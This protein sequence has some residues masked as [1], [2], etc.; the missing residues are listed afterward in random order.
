MQLL[1]LPPAPE[2]EVPPHAPLTKSRLT[3]PAPQANPPGQTNIAIA[4]LEPSQPYILKLPQADSL[5]VEAL[6]VAEGLAALAKAAEARLAQ[7][8]PIAASEPDPP[9]ANDNMLPLAMPS[10]APASP[11]NRDASAA[12]EPAVFPAKP[13][14]IDRRKAS[15]TRTK[16][17]RAGSVAFFHQ[18]PISAGARISKSQPISMPWADPRVTRPSRETPDLA[19]HRERRSLAQTRLFPLEPFRRSLATP[20]ASADPG[21]KSG[22]HKGVRWEFLH[23]LQED[24]RS[25]R[26]P[27]SPGRAA[28]GSPKPN[29]QRDSVAP[30]LVPT[31]PIQPGFQG[32]LRP[33]DWAQLIA[34]LADFELDGPA[35]NTGRHS[36]TTSRMAAVARR[37]QERLRSIPIIGPVLH[38]WQTQSW[39][40]RGLALAIPVLGFIAVKPSIDGSLR[41]PV[42]LAKELPRPVSTVIR[43]EPTRELNANR[44][45]A[46]GAAAVPSPIQQ[47]AATPEASGTTTPLEI[48]APAA[49]PAP[50]PAPASP[51]TSH[52]TLVAERGPKAAKPA[53][54]IPIANVEP[55]LDKFDRMLL[56]RAAVELADDFSFGLDS[57][58]AKSS[59]VQWTYD[60]TGFVR[61]NGLAIYRPSLNL[62]D[63]TVEF[64]AKIDASAISWVVRAQDL[65]NYMVVKMVQR[66]GGP[67]PRYTIMR[68][69]VING[70]EGSRIEHPLPLNLYKDTLF[71][72][73]MDIRGSNYAVL[74]QDSVVDSWTDERFPIGGVGFFT[75]IGEEA[76]IRWVQ[77]TYQND[78]IGKLC[79]WLA[80]KAQ[81]Q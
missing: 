80:P 45:V 32:D 62:T 4:P 43:R 69:P 22:Q 41:E 37:K 9:P 35:N 40:V 79:A 47:P 18:R 52:P 64:L 53:A 36:A 23:E 56:S 54:P 24:G 17:K 44:P 29:I 8:N 51:G 48:P 68:Y 81:P 12:L 13:E 21:S 66:G 2:T 1:Q 14:V 73:R 61:P 19:S 49:K 39:A 5:R 59:A 78:F 77:V 26:R 57:W 11:S 70:R 33:F 27:D 74:V 3:L 6:G 76:R 30:W 50:K 38:F 60:P 42:V 7:K 55:K 67:L 31:R 28:A 15:T 20:K 65:N 46:T 16:L 34:R 58:D 71:R 75:G 63:Y 10:M 25:S 72:I